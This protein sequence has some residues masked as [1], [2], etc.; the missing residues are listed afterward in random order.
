VSDELLGRLSP[1]AEGDTIML[2]T[3][4]AHTEKTVVAID[5]TPSASPLPG[6]GGRRTRQ[7]PPHKTAGE[8]NESSF[9]L[10]ASFYSV[11]SRHL[12]AQMDMIYPGDTIDAALHLFVS[13][14]KTQFPGTKCA[15][16]KR[17]VTIDENAIQALADAASPPP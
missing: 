6:R 1:A 14:L 5:S 16:W 8:I 13:D 2:V 4:G 12:V 11:R 10:S 9:E 17:D 3:L 7:A 15:S